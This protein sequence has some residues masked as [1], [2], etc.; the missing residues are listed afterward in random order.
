MVSVLWLFPLVFSGNA[1]VLFHN[2]DSTETISALRASCIHNLIGH[3]VLGDKI[4]LD[5]LYWHYQNTKLGK[6]MILWS[7]CLTNSKIL[8]AD[9]KGME[10]HERGFV[11]IRKI[12]GEQLN[13]T[14]TQKKQPIRITSLQ[15]RYIWEY[16]KKWASWGSV[17][18]N[19]RR[20]KSCFLSST[21]PFHQC[22]K[23]PELLSYCMSEVLPSSSVLWLFF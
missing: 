7:S 16:W 17:W 20:R 12:T 6:E 13:R 19:N 21:C 8:N 22:L 1:S 15:Y 18:N 2:S 23:F 5:A 10:R 9:S 4:C 3:K 14:H 11:R